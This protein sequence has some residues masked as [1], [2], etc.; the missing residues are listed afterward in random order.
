MTRF[1]IRIAVL[2]AA[3]FAPTFAGAQPGASRCSTTGQNLLVQDVLETHYLWYQFLPRV[4]AAAFASPDAYLDAVRYPLDRGFTYI[5]S[6]AANDA[7]YDASQF[8]GLGFTS[9]TEATRLRIQQVFEGSPAHEAGLTRGTAIVEINGQTIATLAAANAVDTALGPA[10]VGTQVELTVDTAAGRRL[11]RLTKRL[12][13]IPTVSSTRV[14]DVDGRR[15]GYLNFRNFV[16]PS[17]AALDAAFNTFRTAGVSDVVL[18]LR[19]NGGGLVDVAVHL[20]SLVG[21]ALTNGQ[22]FAELRHNARDTALNQTFRFRSSS[23]ALGLSRLMVITSRASAS[24]SEIVI[25]GLRPFMPVVVVGDAT[26]GKPVGQNAVPFCDQVLAPVTFATVNA[27]GDGHYFD[28]IPADCPAIDDLD[29]ELGDPSE[30]SLA[31]ALR[32]VATGACTS[33]STA[34]ESGINGAS[35]W[36]VHTS[37]PPTARTVGWHSLLNAY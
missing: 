33:R 5:T 35:A 30:A 36:S 23:S 15:V 37:G 12:V 27:R 34:A 7:F 31:T 19:Y 25:N 17:Y 29:R 14:L 16:Q 28:G 13:T 9:R 24:A 2:V 4:D 6:R 3:L 21:G 26:Y 32:Y 18:D 1:P 20:A 8:V 10:I 22:L 11:V